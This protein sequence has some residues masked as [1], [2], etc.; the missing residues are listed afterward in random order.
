MGNLQLNWQKKSSFFY[1]MCGKVL[2]ETDMGIGTVS[3]SFLLLNVSFYVVIGSVFGVLYW[4]TKKMVWGWLVCS[5]I[6]V[7]YLN[8]PVG[9]S[10]VLRIPN[11]LW[12]RWFQKEQFFNMTVRMIG[13]AVLIF[14]VGSVVAKRREFINET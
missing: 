13:I 8:P 7:Y 4:L 10:D 2:K 12:E 6:P 5:L 3:L 9:L 1:Q 11:M 14:F